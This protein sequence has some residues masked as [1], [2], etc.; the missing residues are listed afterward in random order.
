MELVERRL[1]ILG[2]RHVRVAFA[3]A[4]AMSDPPGKGHKHADWLAGWHVT[5]Q[6]RFDKLRVLTVNNGDD[7]H[8]VSDF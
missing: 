8:V 4:D 6:P 5:S 1:T 3:N 7:H 2:V